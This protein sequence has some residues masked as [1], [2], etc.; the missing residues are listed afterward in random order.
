MDHHLDGD[1][2]LRMH[3]VQELKKIFYATYSFYKVYYFETAK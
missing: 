3:L 1:I 2:V